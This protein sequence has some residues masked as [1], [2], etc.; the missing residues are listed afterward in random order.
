MNVTI[1]G[2]AGRV[3]STIGYALLLSNPELTK[4][5][6]KD[7]IDKVHGEAMD[8]QQ[9]ALALGRKV[10]IEATTTSI[11]GSS[12]LIIIAAG[13]PLSALGTNDRNQLL[14]K[15]RAI[16]DNILREIPDDGKVKY[17]II[18]NPVDVMTHHL[19]KRI[20][21]R[22]RVLG[23]ST[24]TDSIRLN[25]FCN[26]YLIGEHSGKMIYIG[27]NESQPDL[28]RVTQLGLD[29]VNAKGGTWFTTGTIVVNVANAILLNQNREFPISTLLQGEYGLQDICLSV[30]CLVNQQGVTIRRVPLTTQQQRE[31]Q[32]AAEKVRALL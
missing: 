19:V 5:V 14:E 2:G 8:L 15:N 29:V 10:K 6:L 16:L 1:I 3:G 17:I 7:V 27:N 4:L 21:D 24:L 22:Q 23:I 31:L 25:T 26:G 30:P 9:A 20:G 32:E 11:S 18:T 28:T 13:I 12:D